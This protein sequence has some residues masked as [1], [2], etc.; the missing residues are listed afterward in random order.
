MSIIEIKTAG[1]VPRIDAKKREATNAKRFDA[2]GDGLFLARQLEQIYAEVLTEDVPPQNA[3]E[4]FPMDNSV[5][6]GARSHTVR[7]KE[8]RGEAKVHRGNAPPPLVSIGQESEEF[9]IHHYVIGVEFDIFE[10]QSANFAGTQL[11]QELEDAAQIILLEFLNAKTWF[12]DAENDITGVLNYPWLPKIALSQGFSMAA[13]AG[14]MLTALTYA[15]NKQNVDTNTAYAPDSMLVSPR[16][17]Q[18]LQS[19]RYGTTDGTRLISEFQAVNPSIRNIDMALELQGTGPGGTDQILFYRRD[20]RSIA[21]VVP[22][23]F[24]ML[25]AQAHNYAW[26]IPCYM[27]HG[28]VVQRDVLNNLLAYVQVS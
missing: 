25:P 17:M 10:L 14:D 28:G 24:T 8:I 27:S 18:I 9:K 12:G 5:S 6:P 7:R 1:S 11:R 22:Q 3:L 26:T 13:D 21:N 19:K 16:L 4:F 15:A 2:D 20:R 23:T